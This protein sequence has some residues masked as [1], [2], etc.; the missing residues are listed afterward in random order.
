M[1]SNREVSV[2][3]PTLNEEPNIRPLVERLHRALAGNGLAY[4]LIF[5]DDHSTDASVKILNE[6]SQTYPLVCYLKQGARGK[7]QSLLEGFTHARYQALGFIDADLQYP[8]EAI[9]QMLSQLQADADVVVANRLV[10]KE[11][12]LRKILSRGFSFVFTRLLH[13]FNVDTQS[14]LKVFRKQVIEEITL[15]PTPWTF[16]LEFLLKAR[17]AGYRIGSHNI[18]FEDRRAG[19]SK[20]NIFSATYEIGLSALRLKLQ[21]PR[22]VHFMPSFPSM[23]G[24]GVAHNEQR[25]ITHTS[26][27]SPMS[28]LHTLVFWQKVFLGLVILALGLGLVWTPVLTAIVFTALLS[29]VY[30]ADVLFN[31]YLVLKSLRRPPELH[32]SQNALLAIPEATLPVYSILCPLYREAE[33]LPGFLAA[34]NALAW[35]KDKLDV[36]LLL[37]SDDRE[38]LEAVR[39]L[40]LP[41]F[42]RILTVPDSG[43]KT[44]PKACNYGLA[45]ARGE[46]LVVYDAEDI[47]DP[48]QLRKAYLGFRKV[49]STVKCL[50]AKLNYHN[51]EQNLL[52]RIFT[53]EYSLWFDVIL[54]GIQSINAIIPLGGT[55]NH[56]RVRDLV[57]LQGWDA[58]NVTEDCDLGARLFEAG[59]QTAVIDSVTLEEA[60]SRVR[61]WL[62][63]R[64][65]WIKGYIQTYLVHM[66][67]PVKLARETGV[68]ALLFQLIVG[69]KVAFVLI[70]P[71]LWV[72]T[73]AYFAL[74]AFVGETIESIY[75]SA[76]FYMAIFSMVFGNFLFLYYYMIGCAKRGHWG[77][78][79]YVFFVP[80]YWFMTSLAAFIAL[81]QL[82]VKPHFWE[83]TNHGL[84]RVSRVFK[85]AVKY[86]AWRRVFVNLDL[87]R[88]VPRNLSNNVLPSAGL[89]MG[90]M[91]I[92]NFI[93]FLFNAFLGRR[94]GLVELGTV[95]LVNTLSGV[96]A[97][98]FGALSNTVNHRTAYLSVT[99][100]KNIALQFLRSVMKNTLIVAAGFSVL[101]IVISPYLSRFFNLPDVQTIMLFTPI[102]TF[103]AMAAIYRGYLQGELRFRSVGIIFL[104]ESLSKFAAAMILIAAGLESLVYLSIPLSVVISSAVAWYTIWRWRDLARPAYVRQSFP[105]DFYAASLLT[106]ASSVMFLSLDII[107]VKH[108]LPPAAAGEYVLLSLVGKMIYFF[109]TLP[110]AFMT[111]FVSRDL[112]LKA[113][114]EKSFHPILSATLALTMLAFLL[115]GPLGSEVVPVLLGSKTF[116]ILPFLSHYSQAIALFTVSSVI[117][118]YHLARKR[119][120]FSIAS[121]SVSLSM[122]VGIILSHEDI[123]AITSVVSKSA[124][125]G[126]SLI[127][128]LHLFEDKL[129]FLTSVFADLFGAIL[130]L[131][132]TLVGSADKKSILIFNWRDL[133]HK[134]A[135]GAEV[136]VQEMAKK[137]VGAGHHVTLFCGNDSQS[138]RSE[139]VDGVEIVRRG[140][141]YLVYFWAFVYYLLRFRGRYDVIIDCQNGIPFFTPLYAREPI[142][143]VMHHVHQEIFR[144][145][146][147]KP[148]AV[149]ASFLENQVMPWVYQDTK[150]I[151]VSDSTRQGMEKLGLVGSGIEIVHNGVDLES[152]K[153]GDKSPSPEI[154]YLGRLKAYKSIDVL[155]KAFQI[156]KQ[157]IAGAKLIIAGSGEEEDKLKKISRDLGL[158]RDVEFKGWVSED[159]KVSLMQ[160]AWVFVNPSLIEGWGITTVEANACGTPIVAADV[161]GLRDSV[162]NPH[163]GY[164]VKHGDAPAFAEKIAEI[165]LDHELRARLSRDSVEW[166]K[167][168]D[169]GKTSKEFLSIIGEKKSGTVAANTEEAVNI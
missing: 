113:N 45:F 70:N 66:R 162:Q 42:V 49:P 166:A 20:M 129:K 127:G 143:C 111:T 2:V 157:R 141:F 155:L 18:I 167:N 150:F 33:V 145:Y 53:A 110:G 147:I 95:T 122:L 99:R 83:K 12:T 87:R 30:F 58:F 93:N 69:G 78:V 63:Q 36:I 138:A 38:T 163:T 124:Y 21:P 56:F 116:A 96:A 119:Y 152:H 153:P 151:T 134:F 67:R 77:L 13:G 52:T 148:L 161:P 9:P 73:I 104:T 106:G 114:P 98:F 156:L 158:E 41:G 61:N 128:L 34:I 131:P 40:V 7:A 31:L 64:S 17:N 130:P 135:G 29:S 103:G 100:E 118:S 136:Y 37:E 85:P 81:Y 123:N 165:I 65:R 23:I 28:A 101:W 35:P 140:G 126:L 50:Q 16:D 144:R 72:L 94:L 91:M 68:H 164:L 88:F 117:V 48:L 82:V 97:L 90:A 74:Y 43:P 3:I 115:L 107:L 26:L 146:L 71:F 108:F 149:L 46:Y 79:K 55:S 27:P 169:W 125:F 15:H 92:S 4:E 32:F 5:I 142:F 121:F 22:P 105:F 57:R 8:P 154:L 44:K 54:T 160:R 51:P 24:A 6:L 159:E 47:P 10:H 80:I 112:G 84:H 137:W 102:L 132:E 19:V 89:L 120:I 25:I 14:G 109:G 139:I 39:R 62:R 1:D 59:Y 75:P 133:K 60:N 168:F 76:V 11:K 86:R